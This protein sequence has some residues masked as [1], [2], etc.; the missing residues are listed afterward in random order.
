MKDFSSFQR[1]PVL[2]ECSD[3][4]GLVLSTV[5]ELKTEENNEYEY[6]CAG[7]A[8]LAELKTSFKRQKS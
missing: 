8:L 6:G 3:V 2:L 1:K 4:P 5:T 7:P